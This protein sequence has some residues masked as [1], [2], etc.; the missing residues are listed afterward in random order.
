MLGVFQFMQ[1]II[2]CDDACHSGGEEL[3]EAV[4]GLTVV[5][6]LG[7][8]LHLRCSVYLRY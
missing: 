2:S 7:C 4:A 1:S 3:R 6:Y 5:V 8:G